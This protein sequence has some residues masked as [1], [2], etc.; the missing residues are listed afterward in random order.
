MKL[1]PRSSSS[2]YPLSYSPC[3]LL[4]TQPSSTLNSKPLIDSHPSRTHDVPFPS[5]P[6]YSNPDVKP[7]RPAISIHP[8]PRW[9]WHL[10]ELRSL[11]DTQISDRA[12][13]LAT[14][15]WVDHGQS[16]RRWRI[17]R[18]SGD[19]PMGPGSSARGNG[20]LLVK[21]ERHSVELRVLVVQSVTF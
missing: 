20:V 17:S 5:L 15:E 9:R 6:S 18:G 12:P 2:N 8:S 3:I 10:P 19:G 1:N 4:N 13:L 14:R 21:N 7:K 11:H 16:Q